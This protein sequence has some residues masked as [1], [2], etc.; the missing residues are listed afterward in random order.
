MFRAERYGGVVVHLR[1]IL[2]KVVFFH[3]TRHMLAY[4][5]FHAEC[6]ESLIGRDGEMVKRGQDDAV[7]P[8]VYPVQVSA[9]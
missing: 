8:S 1:D 6:V 2:R 9:S 4:H 3:A 7:L 5:V